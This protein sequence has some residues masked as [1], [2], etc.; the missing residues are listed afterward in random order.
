MRV[1][2]AVHYSM[3]GLWVDFEAS[4]TGSLVM[5]SPRNHATSIPGLYAV[6]EVDYQYHGANRLGANSLLSCLYG[7]MVTGPAITS[8]RKSLARSS[9][10]LPKSVFDKAEARERTAFEEILERNQANT[11]AGATENPFALHQELGELMLRD[12]TIERDNAVLGKLLDE[13]ESI[14]DRVQ[15]V[16]IEDR[17]LRLNQ[18]AQFVRHLQ[19][20]LVLARVI[21]SGARRRDECRGSHYKAACDP[22]VTPEARGR[23]DEQWLKT[24]LAVH[25]GERDVKFVS[26]FD[27]ELAGR[28][29][30]VTDEVDLTLAPPRARQYKVAEERLDDA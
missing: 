19:N 8:Y 15:R 2:P 12:C 6:G 9:F 30:H 5:G 14:S 3:G 23:D 13:L 4:S 21:A 25:D 18:S 29:Q 1:F 20:M 10:D 27:Y 16:R 11:D 17:H 26:E 7:G 24:T 28:S 22:E